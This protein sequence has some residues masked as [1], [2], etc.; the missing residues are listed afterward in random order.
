MNPRPPRVV[1]LV[2]VSTADQAADDRGGVPRQKETIARIIATRGLN[3]IA[4]F[5]INNVSG[6]AVRA[7]PEVQEILRMV[8]AKD[9]DGVVVADL[10]RLMRPDNFADY[11]LLQVFEDAGATLYSAD[12]ATDFSTGEGVFTGSVRAAFAALELRLIKTRMLGAKEAQRKAGKCPSSKITLPR[13]VEYDR[14]TETFRYTN[15]VLPVIEAFRLVDEEGIANYAELS[16]RTGIQSRTLFNLLRN[17][18]YVGRRVYDQKRGKEKYASD[19]GRQSD[20]RKVARDEDEIIDV[21]VIQEPA[22]SLACFQRVQKALG[23]THGRWVRKRTSNTAVNL[24]VGIA[25]CG[26]CGE[27]LYCSSG[28]RTGGGS[29][30]GYYVCKKNYYLFKKNSGGCEMRSIRKDHLDAT[31]RKFT[32]EHLSNV[33]TLTAIVEHAIRSHGARATGATIGDVDGKLKELR[34]QQRRLAVAFAAGHMDLQLFGELMAPL[35][36]DLAALDRTRHHTPRVDG[37]DVE[38][39]VRLIVCGAKAFGRI[40]EPA[41]QKQIIQQLFCEVRFM[42]DMIVSFKLQAQFVDVGDPALRTNSAD[43]GR[44]TGTGSSRRRA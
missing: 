10:D 3:R 31:L 30:L 19:R 36:R 4:E 16:R 20:R 34:R 29:R 18:I 43:S 32:A 13:G 11:Q 21:L 25:R 39:L 17:K 41:D 22:V 12:S 40:T 26:F 27:R 7:C 6:T 24:G 14:E 8:W 38:E 44:H 42:H 23:E 2:R 37:L 28:K 33:P 15:D 5:E 1:S 35:R 9:V